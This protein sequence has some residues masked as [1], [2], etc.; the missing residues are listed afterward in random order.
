MANG[1][2]VPWRQLSPEALKGLIEE[3]VS[4]E[5]TEYGAHEVSLETKV[6]EVIA[7]LKSGAVVIVYD[8][9]S[10]TVSVVPATDLPPD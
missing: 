2:I 4:R 3:F 8:P 1:T 5:G 7:Q 9:E 10:A 6:S